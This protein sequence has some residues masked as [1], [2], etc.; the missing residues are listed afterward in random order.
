M[1]IDCLVDDRTGAVHVSNSQ[2]I[3]GCIELLSDTPGCTSSVCGELHSDRSAIKRIPI[4]DL[5]PYVAVKGSCLCPDCQ[6]YVEELQHYEF[7]PLTTPIQLSTEQVS[8]AKQV[9]RVLAE[10][11]GDK[12]RTARETH[13]SSFEP[14]DF[15]DRWDDAPDSV[16]R[17]L[18]KPP[19][20]RTSVNP[21]SIVGSTSST[22]LIPQRVDR[23][24]YKMLHGG[25]D[26]SHCSV[27]V[28]AEYDREYFV[29]EEGNHRCLV[30]K[31]LDI[32]D[33]E[34]EVVDC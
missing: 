12:L 32:A 5:L 6:W 24:L 20:H 14:L 21:A 2:H 29:T 16:S 34:V 13:D 28:L 9:R 33:V 19:R 8:K 26:V 1:K 3:N 22:R 23:I 31:M 17:F 25:W 27:P 30:F 4:C 11:M 18:E 7:S 10:G 15:V